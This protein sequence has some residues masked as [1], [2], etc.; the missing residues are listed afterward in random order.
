M[1]QWPTQPA[2]QPNRIVE[3]ED[4]DTDSDIGNIVSITSTAY[5]QTRDDLDD[6]E[7]EVDPFAEDPLAD[8][9]G[10]P[11]DESV[12][13]APESP[14]TPQELLRCGQRTRPLFETAR[15]NLKQSGSVYRSALYYKARQPKLAPAE[16]G[17]SGSA[18]TAAESNLLLPPVT[19]VVFMAGRIARVHQKDLPPE[20]RSWKEALKHRYSAEW[21]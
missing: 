21:V 1:P 2:P 12:Y 7:E 18:V 16:L 8:R 17:P 5:P 13:T 19:K 10:T 14:E 11:T 4:S 15:K 3:I 9:P 6:F 20:L